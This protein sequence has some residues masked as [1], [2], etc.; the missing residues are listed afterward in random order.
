MSSVKSKMRMHYKWLFGTL[1]TERIRSIRFVCDHNGSFGTL[2]TE[3]IRSVRFGHRGDVPFF[4]R[5]SPK[6][7]GFYYKRVRTFF[8]KVSPKN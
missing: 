6:D 3:R 5:I 2:A 8:Q 7:G 4:I 1:A